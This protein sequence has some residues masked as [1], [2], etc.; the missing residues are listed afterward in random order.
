MP[1]NIFPLT[2]L[3][4]LFLVA[5]TIEP[6]IPPLPEGSQTLTGTVIPTTIST[7][8]RGTHILKQA[9]NDVAYLEST[10]VNLREFQG[11]STALRGYFERNI[12]AEDLPVLV[13]ESIVSSEEVV[14]EWSSATLSVQAQ[15]PIRWGL[16]GT[17]MSVSF[18]PLG[19]LH[20]I[21]SLQMVVD[22]PLPSGITLNVG[23]ARA[24]R[25]LDE[26][27]GEQ[28]IAVERAGGYLAIAF[29]PQREDDLEQA[30]TEWL[31][32]LRSLR[33]GGAAAVGSSRA[34][35]S[36]TSIGSRDGQPCGGIAGILC[37]SGLY[38]AITDL[39]Q[40]IGVCRK[41]E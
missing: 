14:R 17:G 8:H 19:S 16:S 9:G 25:F 10:K 30:R 38:C 22:K 3:P 39:E 29:T 41:I 12:D 24:I 1:R 18:I 2:A 4:L 6:V 13:V 32:F 28:R 40:N 11:R 31:A 20:P 27:S 33:I 23:N 35:V 15:I 21:V 7:T 34:A 26:L 37:P 36:S 5:C